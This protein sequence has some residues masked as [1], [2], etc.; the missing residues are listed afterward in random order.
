MEKQIDSVNRNFSQNNNL[1]LD[2]G[3]GPTPLVLWD[4]ICR[5]KCEGG[6]KI[7]KTK[8]INA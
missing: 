6:I 3:N 1:D 4:R 8:E 2:N 5:P 7:R